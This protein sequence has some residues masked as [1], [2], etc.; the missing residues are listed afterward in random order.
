MKAT[1]FFMAL[2]VMGIIT[3]QAS[4][5]TA[6]DAKA[7]I[8]TKIDAYGGKEK[9]GTDL[10]K[11]TTECDNYGNITITETYLDRWDRADSKK[12]YRFNLNSVRSASTMLS[13]SNFQMITI[14]TQGNAISLDYYEDK[15]HRG[16]LDAQPSSNI[17]S[18]A[19]AIDF[20]SED[21]LYNRFVR[22]LSVIASSNRAAQP[23][24][25]F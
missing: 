6:A 23:K 16:V 11:Y 4:A 15:D 14:Y 18:V 5:Q 12:V 9:Y 25:A 13:Q 1:K 7:W 3:L 10:H 19:F 24:E 8:K 2:L 21:N 17:G 22:A 20:A